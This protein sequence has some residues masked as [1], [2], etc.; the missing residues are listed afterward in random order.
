MVHRVK[1]IRALLSAVVACK[2]NPAIVINVPGD[3]PITGRQFLQ[4]VWLRGL[5]VKCRRGLPA[6]SQRGEQAYLDVQHDAR[7]INGYYGQR[8][9]HS[10]CRNLLRNQ[11]LKRRY[12]HIDNQPADQD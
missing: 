3:F 9:R 1:S 6:L 8:I 7:V 12:P 11:K 10:G 4:D 5:G 2:A